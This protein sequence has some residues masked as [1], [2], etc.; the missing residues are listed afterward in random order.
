MSSLALKAIFL[1]FFSGYSLGCRTVYEMS[2][3]KE[4]QQVPELL[5]ERSPKG[6][7]KAVIILLHG[8]NLKPERMDDWAR[9]LKDEGAIVM[10]LALYG[11]YPNSGSMRDVSA[12]IWR[13]QFDE[14]MEKARG[15]AL[16]ED[17]PIN[18]IGFSLGALVALEWMAQ[19][20]NSGPSIERMVLLAPALATPWYSKSALFMASIFG[21]GFTVPSRSPK[22]YRAN[23]GSTLA[24]YK[25]LFDLKESL[26]GKSYKNTNIPTLI[27]IDRHDELVPC[28]D[29]RK[30]IDQHRL[31]LWA[32]EMVDN[33]IAQ[34]N[35]GFR[36][37]LVDEQA[38]GTALWETL[39]AKV[40]KHL[41]L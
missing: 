11:H 2:N 39:T 22:E 7:Q 13:S 31:G 37:L 35:Y 15:I 6:T 20:Q 8:L 17:L 24:A 18:F 16:D 5:I 1:A 33:K 40:K 9:T 3:V 26:E 41:K 27:L 12:T 28:D 30:I 10:R 36:H 32:L 34:K 23:N 38:I 25:A 29:L 14:V 4:S 21:K 19:N